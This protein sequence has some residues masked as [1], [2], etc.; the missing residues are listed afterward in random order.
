MVYVGV[1]GAAIVAAALCIAILEKRQEYIAD[2]FKLVHWCCV[3]VSGVV[4]WR[5]RKQQ[6]QPETPVVGIPVSTANILRPEFEIMHAPQTT[7]R[8]HDS[9]RQELDKEPT[10]STATD[11]PHRRD[12]SCR[13]ELVKP[14]P[15]STPEFYNHGYKS[16]HTFR[17][18]S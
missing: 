3:R 8:R 2:N 5:R 9:C 1:G 17:L 10:P 12:D 16:P 11:V 4:R 14:R 18:Q 6:Q 7:F 13:R 15:P